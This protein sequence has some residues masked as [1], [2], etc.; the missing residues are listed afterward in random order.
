LIR[1]RFPQYVEH[2]Q[3]LYKGG[4]AQNKKTSC[5]ITQAAIRDATPSMVEISSDMLKLYL[6]TM[7]M[8]NFDILTKATVGTTV[9]YR[10]NYASLVQ[11]MKQR[12]LECIV[13]EKF[14]LYGVRVFRTLQRH[15][16]TEQQQL[17]E[18][19]MIPKK[20]ACSLLYQLNSAGFVKLQEVP[21]APDHTV[22]MTIFL[23]AAELNEGS[24]SV[25]R[26]IYKTMTNLTERL[27][28]EHQRFTELQGSST[29]DTMTKEQIVEMQKMQGRLDKLEGAILHLDEEAVI[30]I[31]FDL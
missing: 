25:V 10:I 24:K 22:R 31:D 3:L 12:D 5:P 28:H 2:V 30:F 1:I 19:A 20:K 9:T 8:D 27:S 14:G 16:W 21:K 4:V 18:L 11:A 15:D 29:T 17:S 23:W 13:Y 7:A 26:E 6:D